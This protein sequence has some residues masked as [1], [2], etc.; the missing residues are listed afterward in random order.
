MNPLPLAHSGVLRPGGPSSCCSPDATRTQTQ[1]W[2]GPLGGA[3]RFPWEWGSVAAYR[4]D[5]VHAHL[6]ASGVRHCECRVPVRLKM[7]V[8]ATRKFAEPLP[9]VGNDRVTFGADASVPEKLILRFHD[10][11]GSQGWPAVAHTEGCHGERKVDLAEDHLW[12][13]DGAMVSVTGAGAVPRTLCAEAQIRAGVGKG[14]Y[15]AYY[16]AQTERKEEGG[17]ANLTNAGKLG[18]WRPLG[19]G[20][21]DLTDGDDVSRHK[22]S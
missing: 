12:R 11:L 9:S 6:E 14:Y 3:R 5:V 18:D 4:P 2:I 15:S 8:L 1:E 20:R 22:E 7:P 16:S 10:R 19:H 13:R 21:N 17:R